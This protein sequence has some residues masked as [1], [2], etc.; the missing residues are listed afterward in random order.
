[1]TRASKVL[2]CAVVVGACALGGRL[3]VDEQRQQAMPQCQALTETLLRWQARHKDAIA[4][5][6]MVARFTCGYPSAE[7]ASTT[8]PPPLANPKNI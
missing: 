4:A 5:Q 2:F 7:P 6:G 8:A 1:M 3:Y